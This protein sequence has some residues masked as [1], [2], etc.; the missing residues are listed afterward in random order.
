MRECCELPHSENPA[1]KIQ[2]CSQHEQR[3][4]VLVSF[5]DNPTTEIDIPAVRTAAATL[6]PLM[7]LLRVI[8]FVDTSPL[9]RQ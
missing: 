6:G 3:A 5:R 7:P 9:V 1:Q 4:W 8:R 2:L